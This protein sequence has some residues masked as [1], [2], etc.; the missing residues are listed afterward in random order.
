MWEE[1]AV[2]PTT[3]M[4]GNFDT[5]TRHV[6]KDKSV[7]SRGMRGQDMHKWSPSVEDTLCLF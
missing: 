6:M 5:L 7:G 1:K 4:E 3:A 2:N